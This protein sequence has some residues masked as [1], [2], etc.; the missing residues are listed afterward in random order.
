M[1]QEHHAFFR[2]LSPPLRWGALPHPKQAPHMLL[3]ENSS[4]WK[5]LRAFYARTTHGQTIHLLTFFIKTITPSWDFWRTLP[6]Q[7]VSLV[8]VF[9]ITTVR[10]EGFAAEDPAGMLRQELLLM[11]QP[12]HKQDWQS[13]DVNFLFQVL[14]SSPC[15][16]HRSFS[17]FSNRQRPHRAG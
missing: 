2:V 4:H 3:K 1:W 16:H 8:T 15:D 13:S 14:P 9:I 7:N 17:P 10:P 6:G 12:L 11:G 5:Q